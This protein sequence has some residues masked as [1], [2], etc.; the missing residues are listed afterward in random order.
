MPH[1]VILFYAPSPVPYASKLLSLCAVQGVKL[2]MVSPGDLDR[3]LSALAQGLPAEPGASAP[4][5]PLPEPVLI[6]CHL[7]NAQLD[8]L[9]PSLRRIQARCLKAVLTP[10]NAQWTLRVL[11]GELCRERD[12]LGG[13]HPSGS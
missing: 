3:P 11:Y 10:A 9:L 2:R 1:P 6:F 8:R 5:D 13:A 7:S 12:H 4:G